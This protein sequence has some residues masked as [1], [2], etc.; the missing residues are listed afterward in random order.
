M[1]REPQQP[2][3]E[4]SLEG[5]ES[6]PWMVRATTPEDAAVAAIQD[7]AFAQ[8]VPQGADQSWGRNVAVNG[9][10]AQVWTSDAGKT[11]TFSIWAGKSAAPEA[12]S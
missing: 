8:W 4:V 11:W 9:R 1:A 6:D 3:F 7:N 12:R 10:L 2:L 5:A